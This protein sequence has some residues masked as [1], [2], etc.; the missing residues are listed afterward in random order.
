MMLASLIRNDSR[1][2]DP[3]VYLKLF[4]WIEKEAKELKSRLTERRS[5]NLFILPKRYFLFF[6]KNAKASTEIKTKLV[7]A[8]RIIDDYQ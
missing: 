2:N 8:E 6:E 7:N 3:R 5:N 4:I 1:R